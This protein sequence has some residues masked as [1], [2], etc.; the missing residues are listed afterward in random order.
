MGRRVL[1]DE[2][3]D[4]WGAVFI[5]RDLFHTYGVRFE[6]FVLMPEEII[7]AV[8]QIDLERGHSP[9]LPRQAQAMHEDVFRS[10]EQRT[11]ALL[12]RAAELHGQRWIEKLRHH[13]YPRSRRM[14][15]C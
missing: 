2:Y 3:L 8:A 15:P 11:E 1:T 14:K 4:Y 10:F 6:T 5:E 7:E 13:C 12:P 9:L